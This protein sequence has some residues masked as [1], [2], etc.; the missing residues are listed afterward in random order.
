MRS[1][2]YI[3]CWYEEDHES[4]AMWKLYAGKAGISVKTTYGRLM[5][6]LRDQDHL[7]AGRIKYIDYSLEPMPTS[8]AIAPF[9][10]KRKEFEHEREVRVAI[11]YYEGESFY[12]EEPIPE[13]ECGLC[14]K[15]DVGTLITEIVVAPGTQEWMLSTMRAL[16]KRYELNVPI[17][18]SNLEDSPQFLGRLP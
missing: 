16:G 13:E 4:D 8:N 5:D 12:R 9:F 15:V 7:W 11:Q 17:R 1:N 18:R 10:H 2:L 14:V 6:N 3:S